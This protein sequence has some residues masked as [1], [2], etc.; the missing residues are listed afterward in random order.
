MTPFKNDIFQV[1]KSQFPVHRGRTRV[2]KYSPLRLISP[3]SENQKQKTKIRNTRN[4][5]RGE[6]E[7]TTLHLYP[8]NLPDTKLNKKSLTKKLKTGSERGEREY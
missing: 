3:S 5:Q 1:V 4:K 2:D 7:S 6:N 8:V